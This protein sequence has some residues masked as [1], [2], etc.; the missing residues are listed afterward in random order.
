M[1]TFWRVV[2]AFGVSFALSALWSPLCLGIL[3]RLKSGQPILKYVAEHEGKAGTPTAGGWSFIL[4]TFAATLAIESR[5]GVGAI[6]AFAMLSYAI[7]GFLDDFLKLKRKDNGGLK[8]YQK[9]V[10]QL[11]IAVLLAVYTYRNQQIGS[12]LILPFSDITF[13]LKWGII[14]L[15]VFV[16]IAL[17]NSV[18]L[19]DG[20]DGL[21][22]TTT[23]VFTLGALAMVAIGLAYGQAVPQSVDVL[24]FGGALF[25][26]LLVFL[27]FN[28]SPARMF[29]GDTGSMALGGA[30]AGMLCFT[31]YT[32]YLPL[33]GIIYVVTSISVIAQ[34]VYFRFTHGKRLFLMAPLHH[35]LQRKGW[36]EP[37]VAVTYGIV[38][39]LAAI[40][41]VMGVLL[42]VGVV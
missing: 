25:G 34:V 22:T 40:C 32:L 12:T 29:M 42:G 9:I 33:L 36:S 23:A 26:A 20:L 37:R 5:F 2:L 39:L 4:P 1:S 35:H 6:L 17:T 21:S 13:D 16:W 24:V 30:A 14:P 11:G 15:S 3:R 10:G 28:T 31:R 8:P 27:F 41:C 7:L 18:N 19:T 38:T